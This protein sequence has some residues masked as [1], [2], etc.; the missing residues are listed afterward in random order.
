MFLDAKPPDFKYL[1]HP[2]INLH[3]EVHPI[4][5]PSLRKSSIMIINFI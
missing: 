3:I 5:E 4:Q 1:N 2:Q